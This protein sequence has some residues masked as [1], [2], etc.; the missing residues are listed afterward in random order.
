MLTCGIN[1]AYPIHIFHNYNKERYLMNP[2]KEE[3]RLVPVAEWGKDHWSLLAYVESCCVNH[4]QLD[5][6]HM[7]TNPLRHPGLVGPRI[8]LYLHSKS[9]SDHF[10]YPTRLRKG[11]VPE[12]DDWDCLYDAEKAG[13]LEDK[14]TGIAPIPVLTDEGHRLTAALRRHKQNGG[15]FATFSPGNA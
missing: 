2:S 8:A 9:D 5:R 6:D 4:H 3:P 13:L 14:G 11:I 12:H 15:T 7:R 1:Y 10:E